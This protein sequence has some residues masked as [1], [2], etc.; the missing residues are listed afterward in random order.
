MAKYLICGAGGFIG[1]HLASSL[2]REGHQ[3]LCADVKPLENWFQIFDSSQSFSLDLKEYENCLKV[4]KGVDFIYN[5]AC[6]M[7]GMGFI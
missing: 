6:N 2:I 5:M 4:S 1:G 3:V 7:W